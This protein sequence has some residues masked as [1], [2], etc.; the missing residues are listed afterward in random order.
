MEWIVW[1][2]D[3]NDKTIKAWNIFDHV[4]FSDGIHKALED[5]K[6]NKTNFVEALKSNLIYCFWCKSE[7][8]IILSPWVSNGNKRKID[9]YQQVMLNW[10][11]FVDYVWNFKKG[12]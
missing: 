3:M 5:Y 7:Y 6:D 12:E 2:Y 4:R 8:E 1:R 11:A 9:I 10:N